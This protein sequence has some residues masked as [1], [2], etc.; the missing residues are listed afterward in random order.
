MITSVIVKNRNFNFIYGF[1]SESNYFMIKNGEGYHQGG[2]CLLQ[3]AGRHPVK[4]NY[5]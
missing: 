1:E 2:S 3:T 4:N 5:I